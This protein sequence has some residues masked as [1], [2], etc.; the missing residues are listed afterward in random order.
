MPNT[1]RPVP[2]PAVVRCGHCDQV[3]ARLTECAGA[4][5]T[6]PLGICC[7]GA[8]GQCPDCDAE[9]VTHTRRLDA[10]SMRLAEI[11]LDGARPAPSPRVGFGAR[12]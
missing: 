12:S 8:S 9:Q 5:C 11:L 2:L 1:A 10:D 6:L 7:R 4:T 3:V